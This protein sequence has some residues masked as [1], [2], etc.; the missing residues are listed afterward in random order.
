[1]APTETEPENEPLETGAAGLP[2]LPI[3]R[4]RWCQVE[5]AEA[6][7]KAR[8]TTA[9]L[10][11]VREYFWTLGFKTIKKQLRTGELAQASNAMGRPIEWQFDDKRLLLES[12]ELRDEL[13]AEVL[14][15]AD[16]LFFKHVKNWNPDKGAALPTYFIGACKQAFKGAY[17]AWASARERRWFT[18]YE[19]A[20]APWLDP[21]YSRSFTDQI[22]IEEIIA[23]IFDLAKPNQ[24][25]V[26][27]LL[28]LGYSQ[29]DAAKALG[30]TPK[31]V[32]RRMYQLRKTVLLAVGAGKITP[33]TG[34]ASAPSPDH[35][36][37]PVRV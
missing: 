37:G 18:T 20:A 35:F 2:L 17:L 28:Y 19:T 13:A 25:A 27:G 8:L 29:V 32:E 3:G 5:L 22:E 30:L 23:Q 36:R 7:T 31:T 12:E 34:F 15:R 9:E 10:G 4:R 26:L 6:I 1:M 11:L 14:L 24:K 21:N 16:A 33:P